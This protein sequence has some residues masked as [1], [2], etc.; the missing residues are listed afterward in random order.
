[1]IEG[2]PAPGPRIQAPA[3]ESPTVH[4]R[5]A[6]AAGRRRAGSSR[7]SFSAPLT[8]WPS[9][10]L[11]TAIEAEAWGYVVVLGGDAGRPQRRVPAAALRADEV[12]PAGG[13]LPRRLRHLSGAVHGVRVDRRTTA[14]GTCSARTQ[15]ID[16][17][18]SQSVRPVRGRHT[19]RRH[20]DEG[21]QRRVRRVRPL[22][23]GDRA[24]VPRHRH[25]AH[26]ARPRRRPTHHAWRPLG[27]PSS[28]RPATSPECAPGTCAR[29]RATRIRRRTRCPARPRM[30]RSRSPAGRPSRAVRPVS[31]TPTPGRSPTSPTRSARS[32]TSSKREV[33]SPRTGRR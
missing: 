23:P 7:S 3:L 20:P 29:C 15:A 6:G 31:T 1:M 13:L 28:S 18:Q 32:S 10:V 25:R 16:Q 27:G 11:V 2:D 12:P 21:R 22:R 33:S 5:S 30:R 14:P 17:I 8:R 26:R 24:A 4:G 9:P 19:L